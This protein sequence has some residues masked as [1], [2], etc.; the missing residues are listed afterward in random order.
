M[1]NILLILG[2]F[3]THWT[4]SQNLKEIQQ[5]LEEINRQNL[6]LRS[7]VMPTVNKY[8]FGS[9]EMDSLDARI[10][11]YDSVSLSLVTKIIDQYGWLGKSQ[12]GKEA[13]QTLFLTI[14]HAPD[15]SIRKKYFPLLE[16]SAQNGESDLGDMASMKDRMLV[17]EGKPQLY[18]TQSKM[19]EGKLELFPIEDQKK[20]NKRRKKVG[21]SKLKLPPIP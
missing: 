5:K 11:K 16:S 17:Q 2:L 20:V 6:E 19:V 12:I 21:L 3:V 15:N 13:N 4:F 9:P 1:K 10:M 14:Q 18:G 7:Q 8:G